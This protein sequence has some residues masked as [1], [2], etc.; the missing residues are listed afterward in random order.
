MNNSTM[1]LEELQVR[2]EDLLGLEATNSNV[3]QR[4]VVIATNDFL[5]TYQRLR[6]EY[7]PESDVQDSAALSVSGSSG[8]DLTG[9]SPSIFGTN[10]GFEVF[11]TSIKEGNELVLLPKGALEAG[12]YIE[13]DEIVLT[14]STKVA[15]TV[16]VRYL[17][18]PTRYAITGGSFPDFTTTTP[19]IERGTEQA[20]ELFVSS[21]YFLRENGGVPTEE[22]V[23]AIEEAESILR[24]HFG[25]N[26]TKTVVL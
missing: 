6:F 8:Y 21:R 20:L 3:E 15:T 2:V 4:T 13:G 25:S 19:P 14:P 11:E 22:S 18:R 16:Y 9:L 17:E 26:T 24:S 23:G 7:F 5:D 10:L 12:Y 1:T